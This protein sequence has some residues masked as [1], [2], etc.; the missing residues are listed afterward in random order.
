VLAWFDA[1]RVE[2]LATFAGLDARA[3]LPW[4]GPDMS[5]A[6]ALTLSAAVA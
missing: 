1:A 6:S 5:A 4:F 2:L 3:R